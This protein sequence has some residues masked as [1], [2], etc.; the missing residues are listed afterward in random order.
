[1]LF[2]VNKICD[3]QHGYSCGLCGSYLIDMKSLVKSLH[4]VS[5]HE[6]TV[7]NTVADRIFITMNSQRGR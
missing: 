5:V 7:N 1:M 6:A 4:T 2:L 3:C